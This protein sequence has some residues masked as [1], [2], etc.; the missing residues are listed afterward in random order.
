MASDRIAI[1]QPE[2]QGPDSAALRGGRRPRSAPGPGRSGS[3]EDAPGIFP[4]TIGRK[5][6]G[7]LR[8]GNAVRCGHL[9]PALWR[10]QWRWGEWPRSQPAGGG[11]RAAH[12][13][14]ADRFC[15][16]LRRSAKRES[17]HVA[18]NHDRRSVLSGRATLS[19]RR[20][21]QQEFQREPPSGPSRRDYRAEDERGNAGIPDIG[22]RH[23]ERAVADKPG[24]PL[25]EIPVSEALPAFEKEK[26]WWLDTWVK[27]NYLVAGRK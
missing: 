19:R 17:L 21:E 2:P 14:S 12:P 3:G 10:L 9:K 23:L 7:N 4:D 25:R 5:N 13:V 1:P 20:W 15:H 6:A 24:E 18:W 8:K 22:E 26:S 16:R 11:R 27:T